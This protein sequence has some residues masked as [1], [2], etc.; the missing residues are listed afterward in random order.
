[1][2]DSD[3]GVEAKRDLPRGPL[4]AIVSFLVAVFPLAR[5]LESAIRPIVER[6]GFSLAFVRQH[7]GESYTEMSMPFFK[8]RS[9][10][11]PTSFQT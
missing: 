7:P 11:L 1:M 2:D 9:A 10:P 3:E 5:D 8:F 4:I 6:Q